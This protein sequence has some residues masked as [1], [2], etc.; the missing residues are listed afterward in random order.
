MTKHRNVNLILS[1]SSGVLTMFWTTSAGLACAISVLDAAARRDDLLTRA[2][3]HL[4]A[5]QRH[6]ARD[7]AVGEHLHGSILSDHAGC[8][9]A[10]RR[11]LALAN[12]SQ[13]AETHDLVG[14]AERIGEAALGNA[15]RHWHL[16]ALELRLTA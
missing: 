11:D 6:W 10:L 12:A 5:A 8:D 2:G 7:L 16:A 1:H 9:Q 13:I 3:A 4:D 14:D 15:P